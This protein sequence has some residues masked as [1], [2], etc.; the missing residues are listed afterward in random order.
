VTA[1][2]PDGISDPFIFVAQ[3][4]AHVVPQYTPA[5]TGPTNVLPEAE[6]E[7]GQA[8]LFH[9][10]R[11]RTLQA[12]SAVGSDSDIVDSD[13]DIADSDGDNVDQSQQQWQTESDLFR[14]LRAQVLLGMASSGDHS[15]EQDD[16][17][18]PSLHE[19]QQQGQDDV[20]T[21]PD[22]LYHLIAD[23]SQ[24]HGSEQREPMPSE[25]ADLFLRRTMQTQQR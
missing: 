17:P 23:E 24:D 9:S 14:S 22:E 15:D 7:A 6:A 12:M 2:S 25:A 18:P 20:N 10:L 13:S 11:A 8:S 5:A 16:V 19:E 21:L 1:F 4:L 3:V